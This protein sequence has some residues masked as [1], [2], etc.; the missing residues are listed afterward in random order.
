MRIAVIGAGISGCLAAHLLHGRHEVVLFEAGNYPGGHANSVKIATAGQQVTVDTGF[1]VFNRRTYPNFCRLLEL[2][3]VQS[4]PS[5][6]SFSVSCQKPSLEYQG[7][8]FNGLFAQ[9]SNLLKLS[10]YRMLLDIMRF[11]R[12]G[13]MAAQLYLKMDSSLDHSLTVGQFLEQHGFGDNFIRRYLVPMSAA[14]W[15]CEPAA[16]FDFPARFLLVFFHNHG[17]MQLANRPQWKTII[18]G[19]QNYVR[20]LLE[21]L[22][23]NAR[24][25]CPVA[26][27]FREPAGVRVVSPEGEEL[28]DQVVLATHADQSLAILGDAT[29]DERRILKQF[30]YQANQAVLHTDN[31]LLPSRRAAWASWNYRIKKTDNAAATLTYDL[32]RLQNLGLSKPLLLTLN[33]TE[34]INP[35]TIICSFVYHH[36]AYQVTSLGAQAEHLTISGLR[37]RTHFC[38]AYWGYGFHEDGVNSALAVTSAFGIGLESCTA[39]SSKASSATVVLSR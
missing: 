21:P 17:L 34:S 33:D 15:S 24:L 18:G 20:T 29:D 22:G 12:L 27:L 32:N 35:D 39:V 4:Q 13:S 6:M 36:P 37:Q 10:F 14:I 38:G 8:S 25:N 16:I 30:P 19:S 7:S 2:L 28:F 5:D 3:N 31:S 26:K 1:M 11:N 23:R 9:R